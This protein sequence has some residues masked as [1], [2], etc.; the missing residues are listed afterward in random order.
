MTPWI[1]YP[2]IW[3]S[4]A[5]FF[6]WMR[7]GLRRVWSK[8]PIKLEF[9]KEKRKRIKNPNPAN[10][11]RFPEVWGCECAI[12]KKDYPMNE[13][14]VDHIIDAGSLRGPEDIGDFVTRLLMC[15]AKDLQIVCKPCHRVKSYAAKQSM[16]FEQALIAKQTI[17]IQKGNDKLWLQEHGVVPAS[18]KPKRKQQIIDVLTEVK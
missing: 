7:G 2:N 11:K 10:S 15:S 1:E 5:A 6:A 8:S 4:Q 17:E 9:Q 3:K 14:E 13:V 12:C 18:T 16:T